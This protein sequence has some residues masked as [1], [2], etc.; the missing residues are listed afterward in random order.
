MPLRLARALMP[1]KALTA[2]L[3]ST[4]AVALVASP[5]AFAQK[6]PPKNTTRS[7]YGNKLPNVPGKSLKVVEV[8][9]P[10]GASAGSHTHAKSA[11]IYAQVLE[12]EVRSQV[13]GQEVRVYKVGE[14][15][16]EVPGAHHLISENAS[17]TNPA[18]LLAIFVVD[19]DDAPLTVPDRK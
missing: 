19:D 6:E 12:G 9:Y 7:V 14:F 15:W 3:T 5:A 2:A 8:A 10:P 11:F 4:L 18:K 1:A 13:K 16:T 17:K